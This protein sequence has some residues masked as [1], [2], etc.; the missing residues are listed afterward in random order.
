MSQSKQASPHLLVASVKGED[1]TGRHGALLD[2]QNDLLRDEEL[3]KSFLED[4]AAPGTKAVDLVLRLGAVDRRLGSDSPPAAFGGVDLEEEWENGLRLA[5]ERSRA[6]GNPGGL[7]EEVGREESRN[8]LGRG[9]G[10]PLLQSLLRLSG[11]GIKRGEGRQLFSS[12]K[13]RG[14]VRSRRATS[15]GGGEAPGS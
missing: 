14:R 4:K 2:V 15:T 5:L 1:T 7:L 8:I 12:A 10:A 13:G 9:W 11:R 3:D 6:P